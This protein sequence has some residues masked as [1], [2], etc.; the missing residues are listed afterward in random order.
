MRKYGLNKWLVPFG[1]LLLS[2]SCLKS[3]NQWEKEQELLRQYIAANNITVEP[4]ASGLYFVEIEE[5]TGPAVEANDY[6]VIQYTAQLLSGYIFDT[7]DEETAVTNNIFNDTRIYGPYKFKYSYVSVIGVREGLSYMKEGGV[8][9]LIFPSTIG[10]GPISYGNI[11]AYSS[12]IYDI[13][14]LEVIKDPVQHETD[15]LDAYILDNNIT[16]DPQISGLYYIEE[17]EG[18]G[19]VPQAGQTC[20]VTFTGKFIDGRVFAEVT[21][22]NPYSFTFGNAQLIPG[23]EEGVSFMKPG[24][25]ATLIIP[26]SLAYGEDGSQ[27]GRIPPYT[28]LIYEIVLQEIS[29]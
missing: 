29:K 26:S 7:T 6:L 20:V 27:D 2:I 11:P 9:R 17:T 14:L 18:A 24:G 22:A 23:F 16:V 15:L 25:T 13:E 1:I 19:D 8:A 10:F 28:T 21:A 4:T 12:L 3:D 5:G